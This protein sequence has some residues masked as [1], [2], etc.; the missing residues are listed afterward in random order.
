[1]GSLCL[2]AAFR[3]MVCAARHAKRGMQDVGRSTLAAEREGRPKC[4]ARIGRPSRRAGAV[5]AGR[6]LF[7]YGAWTQR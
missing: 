4:L 6:D 5:A 3:R 7:R 1:M 2:P